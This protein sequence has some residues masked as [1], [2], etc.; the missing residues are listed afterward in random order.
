[1]TH[2]PSCDR[3]YVGDA[4]LEARMQDAVC[5][6]QEYLDKR[7]KETPSDASFLSW[8]RPGQALLRTRPHELGFAIDPTLDELQLLHHKTRRVLAD[9]AV[10][11]QARLDEWRA[12]EAKSVES[13]K[14]V[15][16]APKADEASSSD[17]TDLVSREIVVTGS[18]KARVA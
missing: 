18:K 13:P 8:K 10:Q 1:M 17:S 16:M 3:Y 15:L 14:V 12:R 2:G 7:L 11:Q 5:F 9:N 6:R 4:A